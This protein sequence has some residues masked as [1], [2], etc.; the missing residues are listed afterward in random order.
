MLAALVGGAVGPY[1]TGALHD[2]FGSYTL[3]FAIAVDLSGFAALAI[4]HAAPRK[5][6]TVAGRTR[7]RAA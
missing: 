2:G 4:W 7:Y 3:A 5:V 6:R 1:V